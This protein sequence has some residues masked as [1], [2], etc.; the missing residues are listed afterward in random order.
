M[1]IDFFKRRMHKDADG[2]SRPVLRGKLGH[3]LATDPF[4]DWMLILAVALAAAL[5]LVGT[6]ASVY[7]GTRSLLESPDPEMQRAP[8]LPLDESA[9]TKALQSIGDKRADREKAAAGTGIPHDPS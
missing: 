7:L 3:Q 9:L 2:A 4:L 5:I 8:A 6:G 1:T